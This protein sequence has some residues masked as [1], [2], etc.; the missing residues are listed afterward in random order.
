MYSFEEI[1][2]V[3]VLKVDNLLNPIDNQEIIEKVQNLISEGFSNYVINLDDMG[4]MNSTGLTFMISILT[5]ARSAGGDVAI[6]NL[7]DTIKKI[8]LITRLNSAFSVHDSLEE[9]LAS[10]EK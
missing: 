10:F 4:F 2:G 1:N 7:S 3:Q 5:R 9:A 6:A 8:L